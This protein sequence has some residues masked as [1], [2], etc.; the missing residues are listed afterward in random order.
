MECVIRFKK[1]RLAEV[2]KGLQKH[3]MVVQFQEGQEFLS[4]S[5][6]EPCDRKIEHMGVNPADRA[7]LE[8]AAAEVEGFHVYTFIIGEELGP[9]VKGNTLADG[10]QEMNAA[11]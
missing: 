9:V 1:G 11:R 10:S 6:P 4:G 2:L 5:F 3:G 7:V 8:H